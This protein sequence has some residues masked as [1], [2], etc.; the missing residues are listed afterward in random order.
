M[1]ADE[2][3]S[4]SWTAG[5]QQITI[6]A[7]P[8]PTPLPTATPTSLPT[9]TPT[10]L[11]TATPTP[12]PTSI[13]TPTP[14]RANMTL[15][16][17]MLF[18]SS[19]ATACQWSTPIVIQLLDSTGNPIVT[20][21][22]LGIQLWSNSG[23]GAFSSSLGQDLE[24]V[25]INAGRSET[26]AYYRDSRSGDVL[27]SASAS[28]AEASPNQTLTVAPGA[29]S[30]IVFGQSATPVEPGGVSNPI[31]IQTQDECGNPSPIGF[32]L[33]FDISTTSETGG[34]DEDPNGDFG[35]VDITV[36]LNEGDDTVNVYYRDPELGEPVITV[37]ENPNQGWGPISQ[38]QPVRLI[39]TVNNLGQVA[40]TDVNE[41]SLTTGSDLV[42]TSQDGFVVLGFEAATKALE[43]DG[44]R[45][46]LITVENA[47][48]WADLPAGKVL[49][50][51]VYDF[52]PDG[53][54]FDPPIVLAL[55][56][57]QEDLP[58]GT[59][60]EDIRVMYSDGAQW[61]EMP[62]Y[63]DE[64][65]GALVAEI[66]HFSQYALVV[67]PATGLL[68]LTAWLSIL[69][70]GVA[71]AGAALA[72]LTSGRRLTIKLESTTTSAQIGEKKTVTIKLSNKSGSLVQPRATYRV[73]LQVDQGNGGLSTPDSTEPFKDG[74]EIVLTHQQSSMDLQFTA[75]TPG[76]YVITA[77]SVGKLSI[78]AMRM[79]PVE[80]QIVVDVS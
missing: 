15:Q 56:I 52:A 41:N 27:L 64:E 68:S 48:S 50:S 76:R 70:V 24:S 45:V 36:I 16:L 33:E 59:N 49:V 29:V 47:S 19:T 38:V 53:A 9:A 77:Q 34:F 26:V 60:P 62:G 35:V 37:T 7:L 61:I 67:S 10:P 58:K 74:A 28:S 63:V 32:E 51:D 78:R 55:R 46:E 25:S 69:G 72:A 39:L 17:A 13:P 30:T 79:R 18:T 57:K 12:L 42:A 3:P 14:T 40:V 2:S 22:E 44:D 54:S 11:P 71:A 1:T 66:T 43:I 8:T 65:S 21:E 20:E 31:E 73:R 80:G 23:S 5:T 6:T 4:Q 75:V